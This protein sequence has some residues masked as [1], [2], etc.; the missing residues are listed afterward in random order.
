LILVL[1]AVAMATGVIAPASAGGVSNVSLA[2][3]GW[4]CF[5]NA[6]DGGAGYHCT[7]KPIGEFLAGGQ[8][9]VNVMVFTDNSGDG[10]EETPSAGEFLGTE[11]LRFSSR[12]IDG[13]P[14]ARGTEWHDVSFIAPNL[15][16]CHHWHAGGN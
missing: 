2:E 6:G 7:A 5:S 16:A 13:K 12:D 11:I 3:N 8:G 10:S 4:S 1:A 9:A 14:C 15:F